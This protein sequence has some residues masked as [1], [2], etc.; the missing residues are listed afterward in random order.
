VHGT[1]AYA[2]AIEQ[3]LVVARHA[4]GRIRDAAHVELVREP[5]L[6]VVL[7]RRVG[8]TGADYR[9]W[10]DRVLAEQVALCVPTTWKGETVARA[11]FLNPRCP[12]E[13]IDELL[14]TM[15]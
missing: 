7:F 3:T 5:E 2:A 8:W 1:D 11:V 6:G 14:A 13:F 9:A 15:A 10:S 12:A 4:A